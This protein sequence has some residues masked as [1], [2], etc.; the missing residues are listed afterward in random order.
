[1]AS[2]IAARRAPHARKTERSQ[3]MGEPNGKRSGARAASGRARKAPSRLLAAFLSASLA[4]LAFP[5]SP[6]GPDRAYA[7]TASSHAIAKN[8]ATISQ[9]V[10]GQYQHDF[11]E[12]ILGVNGEVAFC[13]D[14][15]I[16]FR[17]GA[18]TSADILS[19]VSQAQLDEIA[20]RAH[21]VR[22]VYQGSRLSENTRI[23][24]AQTLIWEVVAPNQAYVVVPVENGGALADLTAAAR[25]DVVS[26]AREYARANAGRFRGFGTLW[27]NGSSQ[28]VATLGCELVVGTLDLVKRSSNPYVTEGNPGYSLEGA[29]YGVYS[30][31]AC[32]SPVCSMTTDGSGYAKTG[33]LHVGTYYVKETA[34]PRG[35][36]IDGRVHRATVLAGQTSR[37]GGNALSDAPLTADALA[38][39]VKH[40]AESGW[41]AVLN[42]ALGAATLAEARYEVG[43]Y[44]GS[45][46]T[47]EDAAASGDPLRS[48][49]FETD[50]NGFVDLSNPDAFLVSGELYRDEAGKAVFPLGTYVFR[51]V[52]PSEGYL[53]SEAS[54]AV[55][56]EQ[57]GTACRAS[58]DM[59]Q[60]DGIEAVVDSEQVK[61]SDLALVKVREADM[62]RLA[63][64]PFRLTSET[65]G[66]SHVIVTDENGR[67]DTSAEWNA[68]SQRTNAN[69]QAVDGEGN[70]DE[71][72]LDAYAGVWFGMRPDGSMADVDDG[73]GALPFDVYSV[74]ELRCTAN[75]GLSLVHLKGVVAKRD[76]V[77]CDLGTVDD[78]S[79]QAP[80]MSTHAFDA[81]DLDKCAIADRDAAIRDHV[82]YM[83]LV[84]GE[85]Y[86]LAATLVDPSTGEP[87]EGAAASMRF[88]A[89]AANGS[90]EVTVPA[91]LSG[92]DLQKAVVFEELLHEGDV[93]A[94]HKDVDD[95]SQTVNIGSPNVTTY[96]R[97]AH[98]GDKNVSAE[99]AATV[100]DEIELTNLMPGRTYTVY[101]TVIDAATGLPVLARGVG[102]EGE[103]PDPD[104]ADAGLL[105]EAA[106]AADGSGASASLAQ[107]PSQEDVREFWD[108][109][110]E[111]LHASRPE[112]AEGFS[113]AVETG[114]K[115]DAEAIGGHMADNADVASRIVL[116]SM[117]IE[118]DS[119][120]TV[121]SLDYRMNAAEMDGKYVIYDLLV[122]E[123]E[124]VAVHADTANE[125]ESFDV[126]QPSL[127]TE[128]VDAADGDHAI[129][130]S[131]NSKVADT[132][133]YSGLMTGCEYTLNGVVVDRSD[134]SILDTGDGPVE[135]GVAFTPN[136]PSGS[137]QLEFGFDSSRLS[138][139]SELVVYEYL[140][141][142]GVDVAEHADLNSAEQTV[143]VESLPAGKGYYRTGGGS[144]VPA[145]AAVAAGASAG[146]ALYMAFNRA[147][148][149]YRRRK[150]AT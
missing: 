63:G 142:D 14:P 128:A 76:S 51:E 89:E 73:L 53:L 35:Y 37:V 48:W 34:A 115:I 137:V 50:G 6:S 70:V 62:A 45:F 57:D 122:N 47:A 38:R 130:P 26:K 11:Q 67:I 98:D 5:L 92:T 31:E 144:P 146:A 116:A 84:P 19:A 108:G 103:G 78:R 119:S 3:G 147:S 124:V 60:A 138:P 82:E 41:S 131:L 30:D 101:G 104:G 24:V 46:P 139:G 113:Y 132:V 127:E 125:A 150:R 39:L 112:S 65:T 134:G 29:V 9:Y 110:M 129:L 96:A 117:E 1:M 2:R 149:A 85:E 56:V 4:A 49:T 86:E 21:Y 105:R 97:D 102:D 52:F 126:E 43:H 33:E 143:A 36:E 123:D 17:S 16:D 77:V 44:A 13:M 94:E 145:L 141:K 54:K 118:A 64:V 74:E 83:N 107:E 69:D 111:L 12:G 95:S 99:A 58:G 121:T 148:G 72:A 75:E 88:V 28:P 79:D 87:V 10:G 18:V 42:E 114:Q 25:D 80:C 91:D 71:S 136:S 27:L 7:Q 40:D 32:T 20:M 90:V 15:D 59:D 23:I 61:R 66:E 135:S 140:T 100:T 8:V 133:S 68:H 81:F 120:R 93:I 55:R 22:N 106:D 109:L